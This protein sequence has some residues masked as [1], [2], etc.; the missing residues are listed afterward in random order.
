MDVNLLACL[1]VFREKFVHEDYWCK[2]NILVLVESGKFCANNETV[3][4][5]EAFLFKSGTHYDR[6]VLEPLTM[7]LFRF[8]CKSCILPEGKLVFNDVPRIEST[9]KMLDT[10]HENSVSEHF[11]YCTQLF[12]DIITQYGIENA[13]YLKEREID[14]EVIKLSLKYIQEN[15]SR[16]DALTEV[17]ELYNLSYVHFSRRFKAAL[18]MTPTEYLINIRIKKAKLLLFD[19][20]LAIKD[21]AFE[22]GF[23]N[24][25][26]F[27]NFFKKHCHISPSS[28]RNISKSMPN[29]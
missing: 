13:L 3:C 11:F 17:S 23:N 10:I 25:Y 18:G 29:L 26:Y 7:Y 28:Y 8:G 21:I 19:T 24:E 20:Q 14:D 5:N 9:L 1:K 4:E 2:Y 16:I 15:L 12:S 22:C 27:S 6:Y